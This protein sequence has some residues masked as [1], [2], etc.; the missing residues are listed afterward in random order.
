MIIFYLCAISEP[1]ELGGLRFAWD[2]IPN[3]S[4]LPFADW[5]RVGPRYGAA[6]SL[7]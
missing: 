6:E 2:T 3:L 4:D 7:G 5:A 1:A